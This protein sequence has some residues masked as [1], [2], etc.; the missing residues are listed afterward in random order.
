MQAKVLAFGPLAE[1]L[2]GREHNVEILPNSSIRFVLE[3]LG[4]E[5]WL[6][7]GLMLNLNGTKVSEDEPVSDG[8]EIALLQYLVA[9]SRLIDKDKGFGQIRGDN[10]RFGP[11]EIMILLAIFFFAI[12]SGAITKTCKSRWS[13]KRRIP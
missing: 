11:F 12:W 10:M 9:N 7:Q 1:I 3:E 5:T 4:L 2:G 6:E 13:I 8:D